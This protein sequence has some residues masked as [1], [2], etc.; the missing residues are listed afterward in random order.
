[1]AWKYLKETTSNTHSATDTSIKFKV[2][3][4]ETNIN[5][6]ANTSVVQLR[7]TAII[8]PSQNYRSST[9]SANNAMVV[10][11]NT[12]N[13]VAPSG[14][15]NGNPDVWWNGDT[16]YSN[17]V[18]V[19]HNDNGTKSINWSVTNNIGGSNGQC[20]ASGSITLTTIPR[21]HHITSVTPKTLDGKTTATSTMTINVDKRGN[22]FI[23]LVQWRVTKG[24]TGWNNLSS[25]TASTYTVSYADIKAKA[26]TY[27]SA[28]IEVQITTYNGSISD[29]NRIGPSPSA[30]IPNQFKTI[31]YA[32]I[33][34]MPFSLY[35]NQLGAVGATVGSTATEAGFNVYLNSKFKIS[36]DTL[37]SDTLADYVIAQGTSGI[38][39]YRKWASGISECWGRKQIN[40]GT[41]SQWGQEYKPDEWSS[42]TTW[43]GCFETKITDGETYPSGLFVSAP[44]FE[45]TCTMPG[46]C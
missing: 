5:Q 14:P 37:P 40:G 39:T 16:R 38:W 45:V 3:Y 13:Y 22:S 19:T 44:L 41:W 2:E 17:K 46:G 1:M 18:T 26:G 15:Y 35:D 7:I 6:S 4:E 30:S 10:N 24:S 33:T 28:E 12:T 42:T 27:T 34:Y 21:E 9:G 23:H 11:G 32:N 20:T 29:A 8:S 43:V 25:T 36:S 31:L